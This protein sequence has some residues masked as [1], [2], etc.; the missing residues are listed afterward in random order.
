MNYNSKPKASLV[1][2]EDALC[3][4]LGTTYGV[5]RGLDCAP[6]IQMYQWWHLNDGGTHEKQMYAGTYEADFLYITKSDY[7]YEVEIKISIA[8]FRADQKKKFYHDHPLVRG[9][10]YCFPWELYIKHK[11]EILTVCKKNG[12]GII[13][14]NHYMP[15][16]VLKPKQRKTVKPLDVYDRLYYLKLFAKKWLRDRM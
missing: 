6:N 14:V 2:S 10:Y 3:L 5:E 1:Y 12:A 11:D 16:T 4:A 8:D 7:L 15:K 9:F 13:A